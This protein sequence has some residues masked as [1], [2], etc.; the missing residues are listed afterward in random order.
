MIT[1]ENLVEAI[2]DG[3]IVKV[4]EKYALRE[5][6]LILKKKS[7]EPKKFIKNDERHPSADP[8][9]FDMF[10]QPLDRHK[11]GL[12]TTLLKNFNWEISFQRKRRGISRKQLARELKIEESELK[13]LE[14]GVLPREDYV[15]INKLENY[16]KISLRRDG[17]TYNAPKVNPLNK[18]TSPKNVPPK[19]EDPLIG[20]EIEIFD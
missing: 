10:K 8:H 3:R 12:V 18:E 4:S 7:L 20:K 17:Q 14:N 9:D 11:K 13:M 19:T 5:N 2:E 1:E 15:I 16:F 6:L